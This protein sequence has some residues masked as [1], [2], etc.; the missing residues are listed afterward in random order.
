MFATANTAFVRIALTTRVVDTETEDASRSTNCTTC[1]TDAT[2]Y[3]K[4]IVASYTAIA[5]TVDAT[6]E[7]KAPTIAISLC[8]FVIKVITIASTPLTVLKSN[9]DKTLAIDD[10]ILATVEINKEDTEMPRPVRR[11]NK[12]VEYDKK[13]VES[14]RTNAVVM[15]LTDPLN[16]DMKLTTEIRFTLTDDSVT[17]DDD[18]TMVSEDEIELIEIDMELTMLCNW[19]GRLVKIITMFFPE[20]L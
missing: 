7:V 12:D 3:C 5:N 8:T 4:T 17:L 19:L 1:K 2:M 9:F 18:V 11:L 15:V 14:C 16:C 6:A 10:S 13:I 20:S